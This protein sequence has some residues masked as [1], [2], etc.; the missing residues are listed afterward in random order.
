[1]LAGIGGA[2][3]SAIHLKLRRAIQTGYRANITSLKYVILGNT[4]QSYALTT[5]RKMFNPGSQRGM[6]AICN[7]LGKKSLAMMLGK[8][9]DIVSLLAT[10]VD[11]FNS[12]E[13][14]TGGLPHTISFLNAT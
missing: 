6:L 1:M 12:L 5:A 13:T 4:D 2:G 7:V 14:I 3:V 8:T 10:K 11:S 9:L